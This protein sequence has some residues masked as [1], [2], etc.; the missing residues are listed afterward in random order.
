M[1]PN[2]LDLYG[3]LRDCGI[4][5]NVNIKIYRHAKISSDRFDVEDV[6]RDGKIELFQSVQASRQL[7]DDYVAFFVAETGRLSRFIGVW[8]IL[9]F[10]EY[11]FD[12]PRA[13]KAREYEYLVSG[14]VWHELEKVNSTEALENRLVILWPRTGRHHQWLFRNNRLHRIIEVQEIRAVGVIR[15]FSGFDN[16]ILR[17]S[18]LSELVKSEASGW[19]E[20]LSSTRGV[21]LITDTK[22]GDLYVGSATGKLGLWGRWSDYVRTKHGGNKI[23]IE[24]LR[25]NPEFSKRLQFSILETLGNMASPKDGIEAEVLWKKKLGRKA[26]ILNE[27]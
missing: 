11:D 26:T 1:V 16:L 13:T 17:Y 15:S 12:S 10:H 21:Y 23:L 25:E 7:G 6:I 24:R 5:E 20:P 19:K 2:F 22:S 14:N 27:N 4:P 18:E 8:R 9:S 3:L